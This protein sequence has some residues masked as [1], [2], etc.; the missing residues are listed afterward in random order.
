[1]HR[2]ILCIALLLVVVQ[3]LNQDFVS[4]IDYGAVADSLTPNDIAFKAA[5]AAAKQ[6]GTLTR[7]ELFLTK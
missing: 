5:F 3:A 2:L 6:Q 7:V 4:V 1:M